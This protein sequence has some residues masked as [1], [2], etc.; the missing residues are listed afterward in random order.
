[1][2]IGSTVIG[3]F[4]GLFCALIFK[5]IDFKAE[6]SLELSM[7][8]LLS[9]LPFVFC[10]AI[11]I[12]GILCLLFVGLTMSHYTKSWL[13]S[14]VAEAANS[15]IAVFSYICQCFCFTYLGISIA[16]SASN[17][18]TSVIIS[19]IVLM[20]LS[21][22]VIVFGFSTIC[23]HYKTEKIC[24]TH[25]CLIWLSGMRGAVAFS[26]V[27]SFPTQ[28][29]DVFISTTQYVILFTILSLSLIVYPVLKGLR[30]IDEIEESPQIEPEKSLTSNWVEEFDEKYIQ[31]VF[32]KQILLDST[33]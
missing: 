10:E 14:E 21:R 8:T 13:S 24:F 30:F 2:L 12:S 17:I 5:F 23:N 33:G 27:L 16:I 25:Q 6:S 20:L 7:F 28:N 22:G 26:L 4:F 18:A 11:G 15:G 9:Y 19:S 29:P 1:M 3:I 32:K 31:K